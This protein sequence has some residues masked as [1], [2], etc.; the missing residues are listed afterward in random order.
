MYQAF[1]SLKKNLVKGMKSG[2][3][4]YWFQS[5]LDPSDYEPKVGKDGDLIPNLWL[6][7]HS[8]AKSKFVKEYGGHEKSN[9]WVLNNF[10]LTRRFF[11]GK[12]TGTLE[13][14]FETWFM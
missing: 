11:S 4:I 3:H 12:T 13:R 2:T 14:Q 5:P 7:L 9:Q 10:K 6:Y 8:Q 1:R